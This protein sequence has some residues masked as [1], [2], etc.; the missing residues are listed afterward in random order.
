M[1]TGEPEVTST[2]IALNGDGDALSGERFVLGDGAV[3]AD[4]FVKTSILPYDDVVTAILVA[5]CVRTGQASE[6]DGTFADWA[7]GIALY[8]QAC[9]PVSAPALELLRQSLDRKGR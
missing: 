1:G 3:P 6:S 5:A 8:E 7:P 9:G 4:G 2:R